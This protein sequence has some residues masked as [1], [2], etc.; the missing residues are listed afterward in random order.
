MA[1]PRPR[2][3]GSRP[4]TFFVGPTPAVQITPLDVRDPRRRNLFRLDDWQM[5]IDSLKVGA[6]VDQPTV[7]AS[8]ATAL[9]AYSGIAVKM[10]VDQRLDAQLHTM[11]MVE[12]EPGGV[13]Q[14]HDHP[15][16]EAY[17]VLEGE[18]E[19]V[20]DDERFTLRAGDVFWTGVGCVHAF[21]NTSG[22]RV[23]WLETTAP[24]PPA[25]YSYRFD[26]DWDYLESQVADE[27]ALEADAS[28]A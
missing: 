25:R 13:A 20:A 18:V 7:S 23:R 8:M 4:D 6:P 28:A 10:L 3:D 21:Y 2:E 11:F 22:S 17:Y 14:P 12:Y 15:L 19:A 27:Q 1:A 5:D 24:Q 9:L 26:R 16:E